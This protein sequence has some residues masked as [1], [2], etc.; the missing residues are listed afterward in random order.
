MSNKLSKRQQQQQ[1]QPKP[2]P[3]TFQAPSTSIPHPFR[4][5][6]PTLAPFL[7]QL[8]PAKVYLIHIDR[9]PPAAKKQIF[10]I[11]VLLNAT[12]ALL[13]LWRLYSGLPTYW[14]LLQTFMGYETT[15]TVDTARTTRKEQFT[16]LF[17]RTAMIAL[18]FLVF[19]F[20]GPWPLTFFLE[21]PANP[22]VW[23]WKLGGFREEEV[24]VRESRHWGSAELLQGVKQGDES[25]FFKTRV[26]P[27]IDK[28]FMRRKTGYLMM[29][30]SWDLDFQG[31]LDAHTLVKA[32]EFGLKEVDKLCLVH[33]DGVGWLSW[34]W[35]TEG[36]VIED[37]RRK[38]VV[39]KE[40]LTKLGKEGLFFKWMEIVEQERDGDGGFSVA[41]QERV[42]ER[43]RA[44]FEKEG[45]DFEEL[46]ASI[47]GL[48]D[49]QVQSG[50]K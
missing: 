3:T 17:K 21:Q 46:S 38:I 18:D 6:P 50:E 7:T 15:A 12:I 44:A 36:D 19:R 33:L 24:V 41:K 37:R 13:L 22:V 27:V 14:T 35:E 45:I 43:V 23:R 9:F 4:R 40:T 30:G 34:Q 20:I 39:F 31:M 10:L 49:M 25:P 8:D 5:A 1:Q 47:G 2:K 29:D 28:G 11:P 42:V 26:L 32:G 48:Q 16:I